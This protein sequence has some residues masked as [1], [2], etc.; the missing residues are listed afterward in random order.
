MTGLIVVMTGEAAVA[1]EIEEVV[2]EAETEEV[3][4]AEEGIKE[5]YE[6]IAM[7]YEPYQ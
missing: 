5:S 2:A 7:S 1:V 4:E 6:L 3:V